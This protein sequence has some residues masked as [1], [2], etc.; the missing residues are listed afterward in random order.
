MAAIHEAASKEEE[1]VPIRLDIDI[2][3]QKLR[4]CFTWNKNGKLLENKFFYKFFNSFSSYYLGN[5]QNKTIFIYA[6]LHYCIANVCSST[7]FFNIET[8]I[9]PETFA[10][11]LCD[12]LDLSPMQFVPAIAQAI[13]N[14]VKQYT[15]ESEIALDK[16]TDQRVIIKVVIY[17][18]ILVCVCAFQSIE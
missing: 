4:D 12:D 15:T 8:L 9:S 1:L 5:N 11:V 2:E 6:A 16:Q 7:L 3:G 18:C 10:E 13:R 17:C 14:Q